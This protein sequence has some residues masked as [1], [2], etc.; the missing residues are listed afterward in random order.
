M[1]G[2][3]RHYCR[4]SVEEVFET[5][6]VDSTWKDADAVPEEVRPLP[7]GV[8]LRTQPNASGQFACLRLK[9]FVKVKFQLGHDD[10]TKMFASAA[11]FEFIC[12]LLAVLAAREYK[13]HQ[14]DVKKR[15]YTSAF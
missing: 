9:L 14:V 3:G 6:L 11:S 12:A 13:N 8:I 7:S 2:V 5:L 4:E 1:T 10:Y 15:S